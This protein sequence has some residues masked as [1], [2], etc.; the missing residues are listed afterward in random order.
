[1]KRLILGLFSLCFAFI[2]SLPAHATTVLTENSVWYR[3]HLGT[4]TG[5]PVSAKEIDDFISTVVEENFPNGMTIVEAKGQWRSKEHGVIKERVVI[6]DIHCVN[7]EANAQKIRTIAT[8]YV[9]QFARA[10]AS[11]FINRIPKTASKLYYQ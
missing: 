11:C 9:K 2:L 10:K 4:G 3:V 5:Q 6:L 1:M 7:T 8:T